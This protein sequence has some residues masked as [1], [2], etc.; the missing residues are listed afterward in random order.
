MSCIH[1]E[2]INIMYA[3]VCVQIYFHIY[4]FLYLLCVGDANVCMFDV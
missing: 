4:V 2:C 3:C 1:N